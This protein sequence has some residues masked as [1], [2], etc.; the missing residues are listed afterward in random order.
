MPKAKS[1]KASS[2]FDLQIPLIIGFVNQKGGAG[3]STGAAHASVWF[4]RRNYSVILVDADGQQSSSDWVKQMNQL[5]ETPEP[6]IPYV[7]NS[8]PEE[9]FKLL[10]EL[11]QQY[12]IVIVDGPANI[13]EVTKTILF[14]SDLALIPSRESFLDLRSTGKILEYVAQAK[15]LRGGLPVAAMYLNA[16]KGNTLVL[17]DAQGALVNAIVPLLETAIHDRACLRDASGQAKTVFEMRGSGPAAAA[18]SYE[19]LFTEA[20]RLLENGRKT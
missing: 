1:K 5:K 8:D 14:R 15:E 20:L 17:K 10:P 11:K 7:I 12:A 6:Y 13:G 18:K 2:Q 4:K 9:L 19:A 3:K 16:V